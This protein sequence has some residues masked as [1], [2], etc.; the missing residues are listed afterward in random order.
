MF[1]NNMIFPFRK[2]ILKKLEDDHK[3]FL[4]FKLL[5]KLVKLYTTFILVKSISMYIES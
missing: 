2:I 1:L 5:I 3:K 4:S